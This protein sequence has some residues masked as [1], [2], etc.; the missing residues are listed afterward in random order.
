[1]KRRVRSIFLSTVLTLTMFGIGHGAYANCVNRNAY[2]NAHGN[3]VGSTSCSFYHTSAPALN[4]T[5][6]ALLDRKCQLA[7]LALHDISLRICA[8]A[9]GL[10]RP[11][12]PPVFQ[13][14][15]SDA[16]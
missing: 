1:M 13:R 2:G 3:T 15:F 5:G 12:R 4:A 10:P 16:F 11:C 7:F 8:L 14:S 9:K 6:Q